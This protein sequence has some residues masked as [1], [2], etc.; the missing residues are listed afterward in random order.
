M[1]GKNGYIPMGA[2]HHNIYAKGD[3]IGLTTS[4]KDGIAGRVGAF[5][6][7]TIQKED[8]GYMENKYVTVLHEGGKKAE[9]RALSNV[10]HRV[11]GVYSNVN[12]C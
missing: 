3:F 9:K 6:G 1:F 12:N 10:G 5:L 4:N 7:P 8:K 2:S 11:G